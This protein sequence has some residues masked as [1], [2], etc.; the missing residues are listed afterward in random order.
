MS[1]VL[2]R[3]ER[4]I[5]IKYL[6]DNL[7]KLLIKAISTEYIPSEKNTP[8]F[9]PL[10]IEKNNYSILDQGIIF[11]SREQVS[12]V[13]TDKAKICLFFYYNGR[14]LFFESVIRQVKNGFAILMHA[15][16]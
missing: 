8:K 7:P 6:Q 12:R 9:L 10:E 2:S 11:F 3:I 14:G 5:V 16:I 1:D 15:F 4:L 13:I